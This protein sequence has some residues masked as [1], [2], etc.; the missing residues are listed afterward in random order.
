MSWLRI[1]RLT[2]L[3]PS[4]ADGWY[5][6]LCDAVTTEDWNA[7]SHCLRRCPELVHRKVLDLSSPLILAIQ[8]GDA[9]LV[10]HILELG[11]NVDLCVS[12]YEVPPKPPDFSTFELYHERCRRLS[13]RHFIGF[14]L[15]E[16]PS[17]A[18][19][20]LN[21]RGETYRLLR[22]RSSKRSIYRC[23]LIALLLGDADW[24]R[25]FAPDMLVPH[26]SDHA[27]GWPTP[28]LAAIFGD[29]P[30]DIFEAV[31]SV[32]TLAD[33]EGT[34]SVDPTPPGFEESDHESET[35]DATYWAKRFEREDILR[36]LEA[37]S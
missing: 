26:A 33:R 30:V 21:E 17:A 31:W 25:T 19:A 15:L 6:E 32:T 5:V 3:P 1:A 8:V 18:V 16:F 12:P 4:N 10:R 14:S 36:V 20:H 11:A 24:A 2:V 9:A 22:S 37:N 13:P 23:Y 27:P 7:F 35:G 34:Y 28:H 29:C